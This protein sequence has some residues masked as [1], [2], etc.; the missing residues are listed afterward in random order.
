[1]SAYFI[2]C[3]M[4]IYNVYRIIKKYVIQDKS[5]WYREQIHSIKQTEKK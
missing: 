5:T 1:M 3:V 4:L 2:V